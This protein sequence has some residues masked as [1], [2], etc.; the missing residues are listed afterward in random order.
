MFFGGKGQRKIETG[1]SNQPL[2][3]GVVKRPHAWLSLTRVQKVFHDIPPKT[4]CTLVE[5]PSFSPSDVLAIVP[6]ATSEQL[7]QYFDIV[8]ESISSQPS[9]HPVVQINKDEKNLKSDGKNSE[10]GESAAGCNI[11]ILDQI[12]K[13]EISVSR[14]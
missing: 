7:A 5:S 10:A 8:E 12:S 14:R 2:S 13:V 6:Q 1:G 9:Q 3:T 11:E 4:L